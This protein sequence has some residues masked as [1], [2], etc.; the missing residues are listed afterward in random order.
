MEVGT[1]DTL[2]SLSEV[3]CL[4]LFVSGFLR[5]GAPGAWVEVLILV[6]I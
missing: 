6:T 2:E 4:F 1:N 3:F 5:F